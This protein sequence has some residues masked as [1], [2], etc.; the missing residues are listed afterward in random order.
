MSVR[1]VQCRMYFCQCYVVALKQ[2][3]TAA[4]T[5]PYTVEGNHYLLYKDMTTIR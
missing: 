3:T 1:S 4:T 2:K 5:K